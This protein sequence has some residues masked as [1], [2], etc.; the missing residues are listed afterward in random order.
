M[1][2]E[3]RQDPSGQGFIFTLSLTDLDYYMAFK[4]LRAEGF[5]KVQKMMESPL[6][7][8]RLIG[9]SEMASAIEKE[10][11]TAEVLQ[12]EPDGTIKARTLT[13]EIAKELQESGVL[14]TIP[15]AQN[16][17]EISPQNF[18]SESDCSNRVKTDTLPGC[19]E[20]W[21]ESTRHRCKGRLDCSLY[22]P[23]RNGNEL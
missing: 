16:L 18:D 12:V 22:N 4:N 11:Y 5:N 21:D 10:Q 6:L 19:I 20:H 13:P 15:Q 8:T 3:G 17:T 9:L 2:L 23:W 7:P 14:L 1:K